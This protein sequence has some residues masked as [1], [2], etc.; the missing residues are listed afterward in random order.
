MP[1]SSILWITFAIAAYAICA[2]GVYKVFHEADLPFPMN[3]RPE[4]ASVF[5]SVM[6]VLWP[7]ALA[8]AFALKGFE[9]LFPST[10]DTSD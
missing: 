7:L 9:I 1:I 10:E 8:L 5:V 3:S 6:S 4:A 2:I